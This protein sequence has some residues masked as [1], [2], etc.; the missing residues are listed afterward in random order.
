MAGLPPSA[1]RCQGPFRTCCL[2]PES[3]LQT[4]GVPVLFQLP[5]WSL[6]GLGTMGFVPYSRPFLQ[7]CQVG[8]APDEISDPVTASEAT[9]RDGVLF[10]P[11]VA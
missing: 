8:R 2:K 10:V 11:G 7:W 6:A 3:R 9:M 4:C 1:W 5:Q